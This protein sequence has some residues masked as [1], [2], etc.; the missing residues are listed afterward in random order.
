MATGLRAADQGRTFVG[1]LPTGSDLV[2]EIERFCAERGVGAA[3]VNAVGAVQHLEY[4]YYDQRELRYLE[5]RSDTHHEM[6]GFVGNVSLRDGRPILHAHA[7]FG[8][9]TGETVTGHIR[10]GTTVW[11]AEVELRELT[12]VDLV[13]EHDERTSLALW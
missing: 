4:A 7:T 6:A 10:P 2:T 13:R 9:E 12:G 1:R 11:V 3:W 8:D 5:L